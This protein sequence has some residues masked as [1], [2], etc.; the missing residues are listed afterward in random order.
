M[1]AASAILGC[2][3]TYTIASIKC[4]VQQFWIPYI[5]YTGN[6][7]PEHMMFG[8]VLNIESFLVAI[9][10]NLKKLTEKLELIP[11]F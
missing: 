11:A 6:Y 9:K 7:H 2:L 1:V 5:S 4:H 10:K 3:T 8:M